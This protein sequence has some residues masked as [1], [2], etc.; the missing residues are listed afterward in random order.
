MSE[1]GSRQWI[2]QY[3]NAIGLTKRETLGRVGLLAAT[4]VRRAAS[5]RLARAKLGEYP[6]AEKQPAKDRAL[7][8]LG[9]LDICETT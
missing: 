3:R 5:E 7:V 9:N 8:A 4:D 1:G 6:H 2:V